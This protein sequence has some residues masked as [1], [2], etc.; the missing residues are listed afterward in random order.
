MRSPPIQ[1][2]NGQIDWFK[3]PEPTAKLYPGGFSS[4]AEVIGSPYK[5]TNGLPVLGFADGLLSLTEGDLPESITDQVGLGVMPAT[6]SST[7]KLSVMNA[8]G[9]FHGSVINPATRKPMAVSGI[10]L[11]NQNFGAGYFLGT[12]QSGSVYLSAP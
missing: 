5:Y 12:N 2:V 1:N 8:T 7:N 6:E 4:G 10:V 3:T 9:L 11:Q